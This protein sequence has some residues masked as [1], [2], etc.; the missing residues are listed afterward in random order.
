M[1]VR[2]VGVALWRQRPLALLV[3]LVTGLAV[4]AGLAL[5]PKTYAA[6]ATLSAAAAS[7]DVD[8]DSSDELDA[9]RGTLAELADDG[10]VVEG[11][12]ERLDP[13]LRSTRSIADLRGEVHATWLRG[14]TLVQVTV[15]DADPE[16]AAA[17]ADAVVAELA[18]GAAVDDAT[19]G[20]TST[21]LT[22]AAA[23][24][25][26]VPTHYSSPDVRLAGGVG[27][28]VALA[29]AVAAAVLRDRRTHTVED[30]VTVEGAATAPLLAHLAPPR[31]LTAMPA[32]E[33]GTAEADLFR[34]L[35]AA[36][37]TEADKGSPRVLIAGITTGDVNVWIG[38]NV[39]IALAETGRKVLLVDA[40]IG[41]RFGT[42]EDAPD[43]PGLYDV[44]VGADLSA[45]VSPG[46][47]EGL[48]VLPPG[49]LTDR[50]GPSVP[51][52][53]AQRFGAVME[54]AARDFDHV[55]VLGP[56]LEEVEDSRVMAVD[57]SVVLALV[58]G[59]VAAT[60]LRSHAERVRAVGAD[61]I[62]VVLVGRGPDTVAA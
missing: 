38:A 50:G 32:L 60:A 27:A 53:L 35:R 4:V 5:A 2:D 6:T 8:A 9:L 14:T 16:V 23:D 56:P 29:L 24:P 12:R 61:L 40:R 18:D 20:S 22:L 3:L 39:A 44:L 48:D 57:S 15:E 30:A 45:A 25:A 46:P 47:V 34:H 13:A 41:E 59:A 11:A 19:G 7:A 52:L 51:D 26:S 58:E 31:D 55:V 33:P 43:T 62:G 42:P 10:P 49:T 37:A 1:D 54:L 21:R 28:L 36:L 17:V